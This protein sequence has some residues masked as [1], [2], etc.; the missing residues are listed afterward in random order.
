MPACWRCR[1]HFPPAHPLRPA[2]SALGVSKRRL[3]V[4]MSVTQRPRRKA[5]RARRRRRLPSSSRDRPGPKPTVEPIG[6][7]AQRGVS[8]ISLSRRRCRQQSFGGADEHEPLRTLAPRLKF[9][10]V[11]KDNKEETVDLMRLRNAYVYPIRA[12][13]P[14]TVW[15]RI[16]REVCTRFWARAL[17][18]DDGPPLVREHVH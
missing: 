7:R 17:C 6:P 13:A 2:R 8:R 1:L 10:Q 9:A 4:S 5:R 16:P 18:A 3:G 15:L 14:S 11:T 12:L